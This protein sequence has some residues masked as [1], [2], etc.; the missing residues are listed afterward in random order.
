MQS[1]LV[2]DI[3]MIRLILD[4]FFLKK[5]A[6][7]IPGYTLRQSSTGIRS[8]ASMMAFNLIAAALAFKYSVE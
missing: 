2:E 4:R 6:F 1:Y 5:M 8:L 7:A 3:V